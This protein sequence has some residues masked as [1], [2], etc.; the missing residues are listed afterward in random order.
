M[1]PIELG[2]PGHLC[3]ASKCLW[4]RHTQ[5][6]TYRISTVGEYHPDSGP[7]RP[8]GSGEE[9]FETMV[10]RTTGK[11]VDGAE[12]CGCQKLDSLSELECLRYATAGQAQEGHE[13]MIRK[14]LKV[15]P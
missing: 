2:C 10:F 11:P 13:R 5:V 6:G 9:Y 1:K 12:G 14:Y 8:V 7:R 15:K 3:I 4:R